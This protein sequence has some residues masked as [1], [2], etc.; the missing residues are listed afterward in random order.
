MKKGAGENSLTPVYPYVYGLLLVPEINCTRI[1]ISNII[2]LA[3]LRLDI[4][5][6]VLEILLAA[7]PVDSALIPVIPATPPIYDTAV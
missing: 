4:D 1:S 5:L 2:C 3:I 7:T 6:Y